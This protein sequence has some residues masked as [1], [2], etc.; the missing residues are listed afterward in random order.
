MKPVM[1]L[2]LSLVFSTVT[3]LLLQ[4]GT[5][6]DLSLSNAEIFVGVLVTAGVVMMW[7]VVARK[8]ARRK[9]DEIRDSALW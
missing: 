4:R 7:R 8:K 5:L 1:V 6:F 2:G 3:G 9:L